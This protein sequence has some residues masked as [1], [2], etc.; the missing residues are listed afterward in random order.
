MS[1]LRV[2][3]T[4]GEGRAAALR[5]VFGEEDCR[6]VLWFSYYGPLVVLNGWDPYDQPDAAAYMPFGFEAF[7]AVDL[8]N[9][10]RLLI[11]REA[12]TDD[13]LRALPAVGLE[14]ALIRAGMPHA[15]YPVCLDAIERVHP[16]LLA[17]TR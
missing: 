4:V 10:A 3:G 1:E 13:S 8:P 6:R 12:E 7:E 17:N 2:V 11:Q 16:G 5:L 15:L 9:G 14:D